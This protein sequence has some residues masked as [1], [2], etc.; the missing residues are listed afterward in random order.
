MQ[1]LFGIWTASALLAGQGVMSPSGVRADSIDA[2][3]LE[4]SP[5]IMK[6]LKDRHYQTVGVLKFAVKKGDQPAS[7]N[8]GTLNTM[9]AARLEHA[10][11]LLND[12]A[13]PIDFLHDAS[14]AAASQSHSATS[15]NA[16]GRRNLFEHAYPVAWGDHK[17]KPDAF[18][19]GEVFVEKDMKQSTI[20]VQAF[21]AKS[22]DHVEEV[23]RI[24]NVPMD[25]NVLVSI[26]QSYVL[27]R[28][29]RHRKARDLEDAASDDAAQRDDTSANP[30]QDSDDPVKLQIL[31]DD[32]PVAL[33]TDASSPGELRVKRSKAVDPKQGQKVK[34]V[35]SNAVQDKVG[36]VLA[37]NG[38]STLFMEDLASKP[39]GECTKWIL[40]PGESYTIDGFYMTEDGKKV[41]PFKV[42]SD[43]ES[44]KVDL[45][46]DQRGV[47]SL[48]AFRSVSGSGAGMNISSAQEGGELSRSP[49]GKSHARSLAE[50]QSNIRAATHTSVSKGQ[51]VADRSVR[52]AAPSRGA[53]RKGARGLVVEDTQSTPGSTLNRVDT[54]F[55]T[56]PAMSLFIRYYSAPGIP[57][58]MP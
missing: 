22:P 11:I 35:I 21:D 10:L 9:M 18:L 19:T 51:L 27:S 16:R 53:R 55:D 2:K 15:Q 32:Q 58:P 49:K 29:L 41:L 48:F 30:L 12:P 39:P 34:F 44:L 36:V 46:P 38:K 25:R 45:A 20:L 23:I 40:G 50:A 24:R 28:G 43:D 52:H 56:E 14:Q 57:Q 42:L 17:K 13:K 7:L 47:F 54:K 3:L 6:Y 33:E 8:A 31:Y 1:T 4:E 37:V 26:G 5:R